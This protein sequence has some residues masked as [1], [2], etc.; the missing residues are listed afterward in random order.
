MKPPLT[1]ETVKSVLDYNPDTGIFTWRYR[2]DHPQRW[3]TRYAGQPA[4]TTTPD[5]YIKIMMPGRIQYNA[6]TIAWLYVYGEWRPGEIDHRLGVR[7]DNRIAELRLTTSPDNCCNKAMQ[8]NNKSGFV[9]VH[10]DRQHGLWRARIT[11]DKQNL[12][13]GFFRSAEE[14]AAARQRQ[15][16]HVQGDFAPSDPERPKYRHNRD[17]VAKRPRRRHATPGGALDGP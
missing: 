9:G 13:V 8:K 10:F 5:G 6:H 3:N 2:S 14:A 15:V 12:D 1:Q 17:F 11:R 16:P 4:G 7:G